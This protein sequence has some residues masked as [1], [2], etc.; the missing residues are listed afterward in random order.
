VMTGASQETCPLQ[1]S[2][3]L[4]TYTHYTNGTQDLRYSSQTGGS[5][6]IGLTNN[7]TTH[8]QHATGSFIGTV[9]DPNVPGGVPSTYS[10]TNGTFDLTY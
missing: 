5:C 2:N 4:M 9:G 3:P 7:P 10:F 8:G 6:T 1:G